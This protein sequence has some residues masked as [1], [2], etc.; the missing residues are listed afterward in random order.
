MVTCVN[1][2]YLLVTT[3]T[4]SFIEFQRSWRTVETIA[5]HGTRWCGRESL[6]MV[7]TRNIFM[8]KMAMT[9][10]VT[11]TW[12]S[13]G[14]QQPTEWM[15]FW[16]LWW[17][18]FGYIQAYLKNPSF[19]KKSRQHISQHIWRRKN[20]SHPSKRCSPFTPLHYVCLLKE[21]HSTDHIVWNRD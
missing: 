5:E 9:N 7:S 18:C 2:I 8:Y 20:P 4:V 1:W 10:K 21:E 6:L 16:Y 19:W 12:N 17:F 3:D 13:F 14:H 15:K 11:D